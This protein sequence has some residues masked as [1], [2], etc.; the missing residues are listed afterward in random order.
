MGTS[1]SAKSLSLGIVRPETVIEAGHGTISS[2]PTAPDCNAAAVVTTLNVEPGGKRPSS[3]TGPCWS[4]A[5]FC[6]TARIPPVEGWIATIDAASP[7]PATASAAACCTDI[8]T[9]ETRSSTSPTGA[10]PSSIGSTPGLTISAR[11]PPSACSAASHASGSPS[12]TGE[13]S[14][15]SV[16]ISWPCSGRL[17]PGTAA[18]RSRIGSM[19][20]GRSATTWYGWSPACAMPSRIDCPVMV[21]AAAL[22]RAAT[23]SALPAASG[24]SV[25]A[26]TGVHC[27]SGAPVRSR[28]DVS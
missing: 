10:L 1:P 12:S 18:S 2:G 4:A 21:G 9:V 17:T 27:S 19:S 23:A 13:R 24:A 14:S 22:T 20:L 26:V 6:A 15:R 11:H 7:V 3:D 5:E 16:R 28:T 8:W 25:T